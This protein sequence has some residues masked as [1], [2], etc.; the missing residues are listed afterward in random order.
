MSVRALDPAPSVPS[1]AAGSTREAI[2][3][4]ALSAFERQGVSATG[5][6]DIAAAAGL[7]RSALYYHFAGRRELVS[8]VLARRGAEIHDRIRDEIAY[9][10]A[11]VD[12]VVAA[13]LRAIELSLSDPVAQQLAAPANEHLTAELLRSER[14]LEVHRSFWTP[15]LRAAQENDLRTDLQLDE[16]ISWMVFLQFAL[17]GLG[18]DFGLLEPGRLRARLESFLRPALVQPRT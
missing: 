18:S 7:T 17:T 3:R 10:P 8:E 5:M 11:D 14:M 1:A 12:L 13:N 2:V 9:R 15:L 6:A 4:A 16:L